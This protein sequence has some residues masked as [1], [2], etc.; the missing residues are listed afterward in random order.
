MESTLKGAGESGVRSPAVINYNGGS[1]L[2]R[3]VATTGYRRAL[4][5][6]TTP[7][8]AA[9]WRVEGDDKPGSAGPD[10]REYSSSKVVTLFPSPAESLRLPVKE[11]PSAIWES[12][13]RW[14]VV[15]AFGADPTGEADSAA[16][17]RRAIASGASTLFFPGSYKCGETIEISG[18]I[19]AVVG[20]GGSINYGKRDLINF[21]IVN[22]DPYTT[23]VRETR[24]DETR[25][26]PATNHHT[27]PYSGR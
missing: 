3:D 26:L 7:D 13:E 23:L 11:T 17:I 4:A 25:E 24:G 15:D 10:I 5:D 18:K 19:R 6:M 14:A 9:A 21:R 2:L 27:A 12:P 20:L 8:F 16:A 1:I 22:G